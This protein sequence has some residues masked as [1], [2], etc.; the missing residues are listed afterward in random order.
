MKLRENWLFF[1]NKLVVL[2]G[3]F[4]SWFLVRK[5]RKRTP[6]PTPFDKISIAQR[7]SACKTCFEKGPIPDLGFRFCIWTG[8]KSKFIAYLSA[9]CGIY[10]K[11]TFNSVSMSFTRPEFPSIELMRDIHGLMR[12]IFQPEAGVIKIYELIISENEG[13]RMEDRVLESFGTI[14]EEFK[15]LMQ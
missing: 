1:L 7:L 14:D 2:D 12:E 11:S 4:S 3:S 10:N 8:R 15:F 9:D 5:R 6:I 13:E